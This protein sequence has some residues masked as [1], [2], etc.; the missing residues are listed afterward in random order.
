MHIRR[1]QDEIRISDL[2][3]YSIW[4]FALDEEEH[5]GQNENTL[6]P[7]L[8]PQPLYIEGTYLIVRANFVL[9]NGV[10]IIGFVKPM[11]H[12]GVRLMEPPIPYDL[13]PV[14]LTEHGPV[15]FCYGFGRPKEE[16]VLENYRLL[17]Y[18]PENVFPINFST[19]VEIA[20]GFAQ[21]TL[22]G[23]MYFEG[24]PF[25]VSAFTLRDSDVKFAK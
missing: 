15:N 6:R 4:E 25:R 11:R 2:T 5:D 14:I 18:Q 19:D 10:T 8:S 17:G 12:S 16:I 9:A 13:N 22:E 3:K 20:D 21:G 1:Q 7:F 24:E 23:F